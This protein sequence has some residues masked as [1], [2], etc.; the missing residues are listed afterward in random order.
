MKNLEVDG[1]FHALF[2]DSNLFYSVSKPELVP[3]A[4]GETAIINVTADGEDYE[5]RIKRK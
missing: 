4:S 2:L 5:I 1:L 3:F